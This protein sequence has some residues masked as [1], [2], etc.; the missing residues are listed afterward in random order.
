M[1]RIAAA[2]DL[3]ALTKLR[4]AA[5][6]E[7]TEDAVGWLQQVAGLENVLLLEKPGAPPALM[8]AAV[9]VQYAHRKGIWFT[10]LAADRGI[11][12]DKLLPKLLE[13]ALRAFAEK[14]CDFAV[15]TPDT[16]ADAARLG[17]LGFKNLLPLR[18]VSKFIRRNLLAQAQFD[19]LTVRH[20]MERRL[21]SQPGC[22]TLPEP[23]MN[24]MMTQLYRRGLT[25]VSDRRGYGLYYTNGDTLQF[26]ELQADNDHCADQLLQAAREKTGAEN[27][28]VL[29]AENQTLY[30]GA[31]RRCGYGMIAFLRGEFPVTDVYFRMLL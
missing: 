20:L 23:A 25:V 28:R 18:V 21:R 15:M 3:T 19:S 11:P 29:L 9:P 31:G 30:L 16:A 27:A 17:A 24:E 5:T 22:I 1:L 13:G 14:G 7:S 8:L 4:R 12:A 26:I 10:G 6:G 2:E